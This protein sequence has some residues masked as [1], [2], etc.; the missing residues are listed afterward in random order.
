MNR[1]LDDII[2]TIEEKRHLR[3]MISKETILLAIG[4]IADLRVNRKQDDPDLKTQP[5]FDKISRSAA[6]ELYQLHEKIYGQ[7][8]QDPKADPV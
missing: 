6:R 4:A 7:S 3:Q 2:Q 8:N 5:E 1:I